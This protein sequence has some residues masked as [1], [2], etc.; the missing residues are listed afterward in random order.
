MINPTFNSTITLYSR[1]ED[2]S[3]G[4]TVVSWLCT[5]LKDCY[6]GTQAVE[7]LNTGILN[8]ANS[9]ICRI[10]QNRNYRGEHTGEKGTF[11]IAPGD[12]VVCGEV[13]DAI[14]DAQG[15]RDTDLLKKYAPNCFR[16]KTFSDNTKISEAAHYKLTGG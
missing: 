4:K 1:H 2:R 3:S 15:Q 8:Q 11:T 9:Y 6:F 16:V 14:A 13:S 7:S 10:P 5:V 12:I